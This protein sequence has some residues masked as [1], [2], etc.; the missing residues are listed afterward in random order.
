MKV[1]LLYSP[2]VSKKYRVIFPDGF[3]VDF[4]A[5]GYS[6]FT[7][8]K[9][10]KRKINY[11]KRHAKRENWN[12]PYSAGFWSRWLLWE[13]DNIP[14]AIRKIKYMFDIDIY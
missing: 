3:S 8:N 7:I 9:D 2:L 13:E 5:K 12:D 11:L 10:V 4:G 1:K 6:D 14:D